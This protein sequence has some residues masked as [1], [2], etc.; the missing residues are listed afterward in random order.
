MQENRQGVDWQ[1]SIESCPGEA[2]DVAIIG[3]GPAGSIAAKYLA[4]RG[5]RVI[6]IDKARFP[7]EKICGD[8]LI[9]ESLQCLRRAGVY[10]AV[11]AQGYQVQKWH[12]FSS[13]GVK[14]ELNLEC[15]TLKRIQLDTLLAQK[16]VEA[17]ACFFHGTVDHVR[18]LPDGCIQFTMHAQQRRIQT[19]VGVI[20]TGA[21]IDLIPRTPTCTNRRP[22]SVL[23]SNPE[24]CNDDSR[25]VGIQNNKHRR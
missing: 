19:K 16:A 25:L 24:A 12:T 17:G 9:A 14:F 4:S 18:A 15:I 5:H 8:G 10:E 22:L 11:K 3:A 1:Y 2:W 23:L 13:S 20:A 6:L 7:R 21:S